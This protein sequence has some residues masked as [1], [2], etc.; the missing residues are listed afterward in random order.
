MDA[1]VDRGDASLRNVGR[2]ISVQLAECG[3]PFI[4]D[5]GL[6]DR[7][8]QDASCRDQGAPEEGGG[9]GGPSGSEEKGTSR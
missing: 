5:D 3:C 9:G 1:G 7:G 4:G 2:L 8:C 6:L